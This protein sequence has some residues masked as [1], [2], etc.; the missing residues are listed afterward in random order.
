LS[1]TLLNLFVLPALAHRYVRLRS[2]PP[3]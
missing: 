3:G 2:Q 1:S